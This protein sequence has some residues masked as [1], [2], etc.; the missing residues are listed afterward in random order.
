[1][2][3]MV[4]AGR[5][6]L[7]AEAGAE[8]FALI[9]RR[10]EDRVQEGQ[11]WEFEVVR[12]IRDRRGR[13]I[14][15]LRP[16]RRIPIVEKVEGMRVITDMG[17]IS[18]KEALE[19]GVIKPY[20]LTVFNDGKASL[21]FES[22]EN[23]KVREFLKTELPVSGLV[24]EG[25]ATFEIKE[26]EEG[27]RYVEFNY[28][29]KVGDIASN[30]RKETLS[31]NLLLERINL[32]K[33]LKDIK[34]SP[35]F[36]EVEEL[37][38]EYE[39]LVE[40][41]RE[42]R[43]E[44]EKLEE[45]EEELKNRK[46]E[47]EFIGNY[48]AVLEEDGSIGYYRKEWVEGEA[49]RIEAEGIPAR[50]EW[51]ITESRYEYT[52]ITDE[53]EIKANFPMD[54]EKLRESLLEKKRHLEEE[55]SGVR[56]KLEEV[57]GEI[58]ELRER[59]KEI[60]KTLGSRSRAYMKVKEESASSLTYWENLSYEDSDRKVVPLEELKEFALKMRTPQGFYLL[61]GLAGVGIEIPGIDEEEFIGD[62]EDYYLEE[63]EVKEEAYRE[64]FKR[65]SEEVEKEL[66]PQGKVNIWNIR[67]EWVDKLNEWI[68]W[69]RE[70]GVRVEGPVSLF[71]Q[72]N[73]EPPEE[74]FPSILS[75]PMVE[76]REELFS[77]LKNWVRKKVE[78]TAREL[79]K[80]GAGR[81]EAYLIATEEVAGE[82][83]S[84]MAPYEVLK[85]KDLHPLYPYEHKDTLVAFNYGLV[86][87]GA[88]D[89]L[90]E[91][92]ERLET[93]AGELTVPVKLIAS[94]RLEGDSRRKEIPLFLEIPVK[95]F[96]DCSFRERLKRIISEIEGVP[97]P[98][99]SLGSV[100]FQELGGYWSEVRRKVEEALKGIKLFGRPVPYSL[101]LEVEGK[102]SARM[103]GV[104]YINQAV[105]KELERELRLYSPENPE[106]A[107][108]LI[109][110]VF[111]EAYGEIDKAY[112]ALNPVINEPASDLEAR[113]NSPEEAEEEDLDFSP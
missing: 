62:D 77:A 88:D 76:N 50:C 57:K 93:I 70:R 90:K 86:E 101:R 17:E 39:R 32:E 27:E 45:R 52:P 33:D 71:N 30:L 84:D 43:K 13:E 12:T 14:P 54:R 24:K 37:K 78:E 79:M 91:N 5:K 9:D 1:M 68:R 85:V 47:V 67:P 8:N 35:Y 40:R 97:T 113:E 31:K 103:K 95:E 69:K 89:F 92:F 19:K 96:H 16:L 104:S 6:G 41:L 60:D 20:S 83:V 58:E 110:R 23:G 25:L 3:G 56:K 105:R 73:L 66:K 94:Y 21:S 18:L 108:E 107:A 61:T 11:C 111:E 28:L 109:V 82:L 4:K 34:S 15:V 80:E 81:E 98:G 59:L 48:V 36:K 49:E 51:A 26:K 112:R 75:A 22:G 2:K 44:R 63:S 10:Y 87:L 100:N 55:L 102:G 99:I 64:A 74:Y 106:E 38:E 65:L 53:E 29:F 46:P 72:K 42:L 7:I